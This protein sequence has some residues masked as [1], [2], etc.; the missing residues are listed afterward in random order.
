M[1][2]GEQVCG[3]LMQAQNG[4]QRVL[5]SKQVDGQVVRGDDENGCS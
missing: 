3:A 4:P 1:S 2:P 5:S